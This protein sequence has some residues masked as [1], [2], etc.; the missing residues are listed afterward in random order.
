[1]NV[2]NLKRKTLEGYEPYTYGEQPNPKE[3]WIKLNTN[4]NPYAPPQSVINEIKE[5]VNNKL[6]L[7]PDPTFKELRNLI[8]G[9]LLAKYDTV[10]NINNVIVG[11]GSDEIIDMLMRSFVDPGD[12]I[13]V[14]KPSYGMYPAVAGIYGGNMVEIELTEDFGF[15]EQI[16][17]VQ[18]KLMFICSPNN[19]T[20][21]CIPNDIIAKLCESFPGLIIVDEA[22]GDFSETSALPL[23]KKYDNLSVM[24][25]FSKAYCLASQR[26]G[27]LVAHENVI[28]FMMGTKLPYNV[29]YL[30]QACAIAVI[31]NLEEYD[32]FIEKIIDERNRVS[33]AVEEAGLD[34]LKSDS[35]FI[36]IRFPEEKVAIKVF[37]DLKERKI[38]VRQY[39]KKSL[40]KYLR[41]TI[42]TPEENDVFLKNFRE[43]VDFI[44][45]GRQN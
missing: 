33:E 14:F 2:K 38:L 10:C 17:D 6:R 41:V 27:F 1:M 28:N 15:P 19:P 32:E 35:N 11:N 20:G 45:G 9:K 16:Y 12:D 18:G 5:A 21:Q 8:I 13:V 22:Y 37:Q 39:N 7:Y 26:I 40:H 34:V 25:T 36:L 42:G 30:S 3:K 4:E 44:R 43:S 24:R 31:H 23:L 29:S